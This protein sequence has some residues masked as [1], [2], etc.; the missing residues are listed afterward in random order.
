MENPTLCRFHNLRSTTFSSMTWEEFYRELTSINHKRVTESYRA[1]LRELLAVE[2]GPQQAQDALQQAQAASQQAQA[3]ADKDLADT[4]KRLK[5]RYKTG[6]PAVVAMCTLEGGRSRENVTG[7]TGI[8]MV[9]IDSLAQ[10]LFKDVLQRVKDDPRSLLVHTTLSGLGIRVFSRMEGEVSATNFEACW[11]AVN[12]HYARLAG[13]AVDENCKNP[14]RMSVICHDPDALFRPDAE[15]FPMPEMNQPKKRA[16]RPAGSRKHYK[17]AEVEQAVRALVEKKGLVY[18]PGSHHSYALL[19]LSWMN[20]LGVDEQ[21]AID[22]AMKT[23]A[24]SYAPDNKLDEMGHY[25]YRRIEEHGTYTLSE[26]RRMAGLE[27]TPRTG[28]A[29]VADIEDFLDSTCRVRFNIVLSQPE[30]LMLTPTR[31]EWEKNGGGHTAASG[32]A[33]ASAAHIPVEISPELRARY[34]AE[35]GAPLG[36]GAADGGVNDEVDDGWRLLTDRVEMSIWSAMQRAGMKVDINQLRSVLQSD[37]VPDYDPMQ[38]YLDSLPRWDGQTDYIGRLAAMVHCKSC[39]A[40]TFRMYFTRWFVGMVAAALDR[41][42]VNHVI[43][44]LI[45]PQGTY[46]SSFLQR[47][48]P[49]SLQRYYT[50]KY[51]TRYFDKDDAFTLTENYIVNF[52]EIDRMSPSELNQLKALV[53]STYVNLRPVYG[54]HKLRLP[55]I[56]SL[57]ATGNKKEFLTDDSGNRRWLPFEIESIDNPFTTPIDYA[58]VYAQALALLESGYRYYF[59]TIEVDKLNRR[60]REFEEE[61]DARNL[62][63]AYY[64]KPA[65]GE[66]YKLMNSTQIILRFGG[67]LR[68][69]RN[70]LSTALRQLGFTQARTYNGR[71]WKLVERTAEEMNRILPEPIE[72]TIPAD[73]PISG[74]VNCPKPQIPADTSPSP[75]EKE[76]EADTPSLSRETQADIPSL[77]TENETDSH[78]TSTASGDERPF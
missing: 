38:A 6:Q 22:W 51:N 39:D 17:A 63:L 19:A 74:E 25:C 7:Y 20:R 28:R 54:H 9:D 40:A 12:D 23:F 15:A 21:E 61:N 72:E 24:D 69:N 50:I 43:F 34:E 66:D 76:R 78:N 55:H 53:T 32:T 18:A 45:G 8:I 33:A 58:G 48:L 4:Y 2:E 35:Q 70:Q 57:C 52:D 65:E 62:V 47:V 14:T 13:V 75:N 49:P 60:N 46:K 44:V 59:D 56:A 29:T 68:L 64:R 73:R 5:G 16:G 71:F 41:K 30:I 31:E 42:T 67:A 11:R 36:T 26:C 1:T 10:D 27:G 37:Y 3:A 77:F